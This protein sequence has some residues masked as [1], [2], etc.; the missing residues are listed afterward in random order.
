MTTSYTDGGYGPVTKVRVRIT[1]A[2]GEVMFNTGLIF[3]T[4][5]PTVVLLWER[6][7]MESP[8]R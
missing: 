5:V 3:C 6:S 8:K 2:I 4:G 1:Q 7:P